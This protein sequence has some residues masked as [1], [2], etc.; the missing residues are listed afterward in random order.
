VSV[1]LLGWSY[2]FE[3]WWVV[4]YCSQSV[5]DLHRQDDCHEASIS[6]TTH[7]TSVADNSYIKCKDCVNVLISVHT[8]NASSSETVRCSD[9]IK[10]A[11][12]WLGVNKT[13][14]KDHSFIQREKL[15]CRDDCCTV[16][17]I[18]DMLLSI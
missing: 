4:M 9:V 16:C 1:L 6:D 5:T 8:M 7:Y 15:S 2:R 12:H 3:A 10:T 11:N 13:T 14:V 17:L 18:E